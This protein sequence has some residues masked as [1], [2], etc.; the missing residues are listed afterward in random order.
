MA[1]ST[2]SLL[3]A[4]SPTFDGPA[5]AIRCAAALRDALRADHVEIHAGLHT[6][7]IEL[8][9]GDVLDIGVHIAWR[10]AAMA[11]PGEILISRTVTDLVA[12]SG[13]AFEDR[14]EHEL[15]GV[16]GHWRL[17]AVAA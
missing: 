9:W 4:M 15:R 16:L 8:R 10:V 11:G 17:F 3:S 5:R 2:W 13:I 14:G 7:E 6:G 12:G 1:P